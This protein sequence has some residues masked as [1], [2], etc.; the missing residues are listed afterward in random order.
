VLDGK[1][2]TEVIGFSELVIPLGH[3]LPYWRIERWRNG[4]L[5]IQHVSSVE[6]RMDGRAR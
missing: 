2:A 5:V 1:G 4:K 6:M 3:L